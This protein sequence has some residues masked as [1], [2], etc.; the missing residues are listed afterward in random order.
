LYASSHEGIKTHD[1]TQKKKITSHGFILKQACDFVYSLYVGRDKNV[2]DN[3][4]LKQNNFLTNQ[5]VV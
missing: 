3:V 5:L 1:V 2:F 4:N